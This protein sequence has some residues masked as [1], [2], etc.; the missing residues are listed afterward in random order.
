MRNKSCIEKRNQRIRQRMAELEKKNPKWRT[1]CI[2]ELLADEFYL[3]Q[4]TVE[5][6]LCGRTVKVARVA[7]KDE[8]Q[9][10]IFAFPPDSASEEKE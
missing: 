5:N 3:A 6:I 1:E 7:V 4:R 10:S 2:I 9:L 8:R